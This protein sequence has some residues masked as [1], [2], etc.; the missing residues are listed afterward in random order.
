MEKQ[1]LLNR[2]N[3]EQVANKIESLWDNSHS[4]KSNSKYEKKKLIIKLIT[5]G[6]EK[7]RISLKLEN[8]N[9]YIDSNN[10]NLLSE[11]L[12]E[13]FNNDRD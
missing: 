5:S 4:D 6:K 3:K 12:R 9:S 1:K 11:L 7:K 2:T 13:F 8:S 10:Y